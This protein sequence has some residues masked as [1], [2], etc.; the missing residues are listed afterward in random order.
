MAIM[1][2]KQDWQPH[3]AG[4]Y[5]ATINGVK[6]LETQWGTRLMWQ[7]ETGTK[8]ADGNELGVNH[9]TSL[10]LSNNSKLTELVEVATGKSLSELPSKFDV[11]SIIGT[12]IQ[13]NV[14]HEKKD[15]GSTQSKIQGIF[16]IPPQPGAVGGNA[17]PPPQPVQAP[18][19]IDDVPF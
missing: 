3:P 12:Q 19:T 13:I 2:E 10:N 15:D 17:P 8:D 5:Y 1:V 9:F 7:L 11:E 4:A 6:E 16:P 18:S 14:I